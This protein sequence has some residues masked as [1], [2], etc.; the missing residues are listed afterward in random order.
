MIISHITPFVDGS[1]TTTFA[2]RRERPVHSRRHERIDFTNGVYLGGELRYFHSGP[3]T[4]YPRPARPINREGDF[5]RRQKVGISFEQRPKSP[6][7]SR[8]CYISFYSESFVKL[9]SSKSLTGK[10]FARF[11][12]SLA[13]P[14]IFVDNVSHQ[15]YPRRG[16]SCLIYRYG[17]YIS[18]NCDKYNSSWIV[19]YLSPSFTYI[20]TGKL[21][22]RSFVCGM[23]ML[24]H[25]YTYILSLSYIYIHNRPV[26][27]FHRFSIFSKKNNV[28]YV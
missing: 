23:F 27:M 20:L 14:S 26:A 12:R 15:I 5:R 24:F 2:S 10:T 21:I 28:N 8:E 17:R 3:E 25:A 1:N 18:Q 11:E 16:M 22:S 9:T 4:E 7:S 19:L 6:R 13:Q